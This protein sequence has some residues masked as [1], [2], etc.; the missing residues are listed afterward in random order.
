MSTLRPSG[1]NVSP[2]RTTSPF[3]KPASDKELTHE[4]IAADLVAFSEAGGLVEVL[5]VTPLR[6]KPEKDAAAAT[7]SGA[8]EKKPAPGRPRGG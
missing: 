4:R 6:R 8:P 7:N 3:G 5:G 1:T 2:P